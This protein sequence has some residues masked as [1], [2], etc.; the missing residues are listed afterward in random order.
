MRFYRKVVVS[1]DEYESW[2]RAAAI[3]EASAAT[4]MDSPSP[5]P[6]AVGTAALLE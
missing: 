5:A 1:N 4:E 6:I 3:A 2:K